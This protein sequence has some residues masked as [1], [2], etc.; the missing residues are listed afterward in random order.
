MKYKTKKQQAIKQMKQ[1]G[2]LDDYIQEF[3]NNNMICYFEEFGGY[4]AFQRPEVLEKARKIEEK[5]NCVVYAITHE[6]TEF[7]ECYSFL[8]V[9]DYKSEWEY[10]FSQ[11]S[12]NIFYTYAYVWNK[13]DDF[14]SEF[15][16]I[17]IQSFGGGIRRIG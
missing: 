3:E 15:G 13:D 4:W 16:T 10:S 6:F 9:S 5:Y 17:E 11:Q 2:I 1:I 14:C 7:G 8:I 12:K